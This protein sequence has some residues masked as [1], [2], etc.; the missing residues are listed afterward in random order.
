MSYKIRSGSKA[1]KAMVL[2]EEGYTYS[3]T[4]F[5]WKKCG[6]QSTVRID[7]KSHEIQDQLLVTWS[8]KR[9]RKDRKD[10][11]RI[12]EK[13]RNLVESKSRMKSEMKKGGKKY[14]QLTLMED[15]QISFNE[16]QLEID[17]RFDGYYGIEY[18]D[19]TLTPEQVLG[20]YHGLWKIEESFRVLK[21]N[22]EARPIYIWSEDSIQGHFVLCYLALVLQ[23]LLEYHLH[24]KGID[25]STEAI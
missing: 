21:S 8:L 18:S 4:D 17:E 20:A 25:F 22:L 2:E 7:S 1:A 23:R 13:S 5:K 12:V 6:F 14:V 19:A 11:E 15:D 10:R 9:E 16:K 24:E 3:S